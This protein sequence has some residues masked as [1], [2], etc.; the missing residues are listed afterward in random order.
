V[1]R[2]PKR[3]QAF[4]DGTELD[5]FDDLPEDTEK[6]RKFRVQPTGRGNVSSSRGEK[7]SSASTVSG[8]TLGRKAGGTLRRPPS[9]ASSHG[10][11]GESTFSLEQRFDYSVLIRTDG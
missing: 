6:E 10:S 1:M 9:S 3:I 2:K 8:G 5:A 11:V 4:S 7:G